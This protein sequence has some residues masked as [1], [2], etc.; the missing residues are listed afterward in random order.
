V[1]NL[2]NLDRLPPFSLFVA[3]PLKTGW[4]GLTCAGR[5]PPA[6]RRDRLTPL[7]TPLRAQHAETT[8]NHQRRNQ[9]RYAN[10]A[11]YSNAQKRM[12]ADYGSEGRECVP[13][14]LPSDCSSS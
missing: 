2:K 3:L 12:T 1:E 4:I 10:S 8:G 5:R 11:T 6:G 7:L 13:S 9:L 14:D